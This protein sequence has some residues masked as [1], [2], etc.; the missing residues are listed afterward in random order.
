MFG[1]NSVRSGHG[2]GHILNNIDACGMEA[3]YIPFSPNR[4]S[5]PGRI[6]IYFYI[7]Y[8]IY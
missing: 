2:F 5:G 1:E 8:I 4:I 3:S 7:Q 6:M